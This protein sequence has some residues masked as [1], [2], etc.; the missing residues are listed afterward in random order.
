MIAGIPESAQITKNSPK[1]YESTINPEEL[2][3]NLDGKVPNKN[4]PAY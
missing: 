3:I 1:P 4:K 2:E